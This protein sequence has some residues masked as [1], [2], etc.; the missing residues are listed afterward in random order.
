MWY[1][2]WKWWIN[3]PALSRPTS[4]RFFVMRQSRQAFSSRN[5]APCECFCYHLHPSP[6]DMTLQPPLASVALKRIP[7]ARGKRAP[8]A[9]S[10]AGGFYRRPSLESVADSVA[11]EVCHL[12]LVAARAPLGVLDE[13]AQSDS[14]RATILP[15]PAGVETAAP[16]PSCGVRE[17]PHHDARSDSSVQ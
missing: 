2:H 6:R 3:R 16:S 17:L 1:C 8:R 4:G 10:I 15:V 9:R 13:D 12:A 14:R 11:L 5:E 7:A